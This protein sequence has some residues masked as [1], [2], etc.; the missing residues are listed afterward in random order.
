MKTNVN[1]L[2]L[3]NVDLFYCVTIWNHEIN[4]QGN[5]SSELIK[6]CKYE[7]KVNLTPNDEGWLKGELNSIEL[8]NLKITLT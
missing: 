8:G 7:L 5:M 1:R 4:L 6:Y 2:S 3:I